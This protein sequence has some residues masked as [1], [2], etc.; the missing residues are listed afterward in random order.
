MSQRVA[1]DRPFISGMNTDQPDHQIEANETTL[2]Q[3]L[4]APE[5][6]ARQRKGWSYFNST[7]AGSF[8]MDGVCRFKYTLADVTR[9]LGLRDGFGQTHIIPSSGS[10]TV[11]DLVNG[12][13]MASDYLPRAFYNDEL[14]LCSQSGNQPML[15]YSGGAQEVS[16]SGLG[17]P[18]TVAN[19]GTL[20]LSSGSWSEAPAAGSYITT[21]MQSMD[22]LRYSLKILNGSTTEVAL[23]GVLATA[24]ATG[25]AGSAS[26]DAY[27]LTNGLASIYDAGTVTFSSQT[28]TGYGTKWSDDYSARSGDV[29]LVNDDGTWRSGGAIGTVASNTSITGT[30]ITSAIST[31]SEYMIARPVPAKEAEVHGGSLFMA[32][33]E[34]FPSRVYVAPPG[35][36]PSFPPGFELPYDISVAATSTNVN[37][38]LLDFVDV[39]SALDGDPVVALLSSPNPLLVVNR[40]SL[41]GIFGRYPNFALEK[42]E[43]HVGCIDIRSAFSANVG[44]FWAGEE[45]IYLFSGGQVIDLTSAKINR[46]WRAL[47][48]GFDYGTNDYCAMGEVYDHLFCHITTDGGTT[49]R[50]YVYDIKNRAWSS[51]FTNHNARYFFSSQV[52]GEAEELYW[53]GDDDQGRV[54]RSAEVVNG[55]GT[56]K[57]DDGTSPRMQARTAVDLGGSIEQERLMLDLAVHANVYDSAAAGSTKMDVSVAHGGGLGDGAADTT[58]EMFTINSDTT[59]RVDRAFEGSVN[60]HGRRLQVQVDV[61]TTGTDNTTT[62]AEVHRIEARVV[63]LMEGT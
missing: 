59:D 12:S 15:R 51:R 13:T 17:T 26:I 30:F 28:A 5:G 22:A 42:I 20:D 23:D 45:G 54:M 56:A 63:P 3:D 34:Q 11:V 18:D 25:G 1:I 10:S 58:D 7:A 47:T 36:N 32:G 8:D 35:W 27:G 24:A 2:A 55:T 41:Y 53:V 49:Q 40:A 6:I 9:T 31:K 16:A 4:I 44:Q 19:Q 37:D 57:D 61:D 14:I 33:V 46:E 43:D 38:F 60:K 48:D 39:P 62:K 52:D 29:F 21:Y 50:T